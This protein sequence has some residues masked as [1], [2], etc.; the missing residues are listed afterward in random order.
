MAVPPPRLPSV[1]STQI[2]QLYHRWVVSGP[3]WATLS[4]IIRESPTSCCF[5]ASRR[6]AAR[7]RCDAASDWVEFCAISIKRRRESPRHFGR[8]GALGLPQTLGYVLF[9]TITDDKPMS[10]MLP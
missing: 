8:E 5:L 9:M 6:R 2:R 4:E 7:S 3:K 1:L 10:K